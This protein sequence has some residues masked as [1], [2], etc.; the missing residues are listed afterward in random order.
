MGS[1]Q[2]Q[3]ATFH[4]LAEGRHDYKQFIFIDDTAG[5]AALQVF[6]ENA[7]ALAI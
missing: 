1:G 5:E 2:E 3:Q 4:E 6:T 7:A